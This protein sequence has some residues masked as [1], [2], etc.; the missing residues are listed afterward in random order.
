LLL[1]CLFTET[2]RNSKGISGVQKNSENFSRK[3]KKIEIIGGTDVNWSPQIDYFREII[4][5][6]YEQYA[7]KI[8]LTLE[9][10]GYYPKGNGKI[11][12]KIKPKYTLETINQSKPLNL[13]EQGKLLQIKGI[14]HAS[15]DIQ[16]AEVA[17][18]QAKAAK[19]LLT[20]LKVPINIVHSYSNTESTGSGI[21]LWAIFSDEKTEIGY[22]DQIRLG[23]DILGE[24][25]KP[26]EV[27]GKE[28]AINLLGEIN[29]KAV[30]DQH[31]ADNLIPLLALTKGSIKTSKITEHTKTNIYTVE[32]FL[33]KTFEIEKNIIKTI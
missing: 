27:V 9:K 22:K 29:E 18:R 25:G 32:Q 5:P 15:I 24:K 23:S 33:G 13:T 14:S 4:L 19:L 17:E 26:A 11:T 10:R 7:E 20:D 28:A 31:L 8:E 12:L 3:T 1:P 6:I 16:K 21:T 2:I 30:V